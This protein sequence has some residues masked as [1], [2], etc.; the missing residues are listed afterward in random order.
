[1]VVKNLL[2]VGCV[3]HPE[4]GRCTTAR[5]RTIDIR[6][7]ELTDEQWEKLAPLLPEPEAP[8][9]GGPK[10]VPNRPVVEGLL[11]VLRNGGRWKALPPGYPSPSTYSSGRSAASGWRRGRR[12]WMS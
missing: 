6:Q 8:P 1:L 9:K 10:P 11:W 2:A 3:V 7:P 5:K 12:S 4:I